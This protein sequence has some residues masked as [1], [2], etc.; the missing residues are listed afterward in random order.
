MRILLVSPE[1]VVTFW[2]WKY[3]LDLISKKAA[4]PPLGL[5]TVAAMLPKTWSLKLVDMNARHKLKDK[6]IKRADYVFIGAM[7]TQK[8]STLEVITRCKKL[9][10]KIVLGG[11]ILEMGCDDF[12]DVD[13]C[14]L[15]EVEY[16]ISRFLLD[17]Q[18]GKADKFY[19]PKEFPDLS[20]SP[21]PR[22]DLI[23][24]GDYAS[25]IL[26]T[27]KGCPYRCTFC[28]IKAINGKALRAKS[29]QQFI[30]ELE[31]IYKTGYRDSLMIADDNF[32]G[33]KRE[34]KELLKLLIEWQRAHKY[35]FEFTAEVDITLADDDELMEMMVLA[36]FKKLFLGLETPIKESLEECGKT[37]N[38]HRDMVACVKKIQNYGLVPMTGL[39]VGFDN[40]PPDTFADEMI[41]FIQKTG[42]CIAMVSVLQAIPKTEL[43]NKLEQEGRLIENS[44]GNN[45]DCWPNFKTKMQIGVLVKGCKKIW[46][47]IYSPEKYS[48]RICVFLREYDASK[49]VPRRINL[50]KIKAFIRSVWYI[51]VVGDPESRYYYWKTLFF[52]FKNHRQAF[53]EAVS[54]Q[55]YG[56]H[57]NKFAKDIENS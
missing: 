42:I 9:G 30:R 7:I 54:L 56:A 51:G 47:T 14:L 45:T 27:R 13:H 1:F 49:R 21:I 16:T 57:F 25:L 34:V 6:D 52:A 50:L 43:H 53:S 12:A 15:G 35:P 26:Q 22:W 44:S 37:Q 5:L 40:D 3:L 41:D 36:G 19:L 55:I 32:I 8:A 29:A 20:N 38:L 24:I 48:E 2:S 10:K 4:F 33:N 28:N 18:S 17:L 23:K 39:I 46:S 11:P 31:A